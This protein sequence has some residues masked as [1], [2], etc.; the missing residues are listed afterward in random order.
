MSNATGTARRRQPCVRC[1]NHYATTRLHRESPIP[2]ALKWTWQDRALCRSCAYIEM[3]AVLLA[4]PTTDIT[5]AARPLHSG[6]L[7]V[8]S[9]VTR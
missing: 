6:C 9:L 7:S 5:I 4:H 3:Q 2:E 1:R 8:L